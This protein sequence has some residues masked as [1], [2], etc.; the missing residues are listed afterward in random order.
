MKKQLVLRIAPYLLLV[1]GLAGCN[2]LALPGEAILSHRV[3]SP[4]AITIPAGLS[5]DQT[6]VAI[7]TALE[8][9]Y[10]AVNPSVV[11]IQVS[12]KETLSQMP[13][14]SPMPF[15]FFRQPD[16]SQNQ[17]DQEPEEFY[18]H[19][20]GSGFVWD[21]EGHIVTNNHVVEAADKISVTFADGASVPA[22]VVGT[23]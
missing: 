21:K 14:S 7:E 2:A 6:L 19:G 8:D 11:S 16:S 12:Q 10:S 17:P 1:P 5:K 20:T 13:P 4:P 23:E 18:R 22:E 3:E 9:I 15:F